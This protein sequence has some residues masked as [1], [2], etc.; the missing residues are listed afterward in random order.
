MAD[1]SIKMRELKS[2]LSRYGVDA[3]ESRGKG[4]HVLF[5]KKFAEGVFTYPVPTHN[6]DVKFVT[7]VHVERNFD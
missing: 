4:S 3:D 5:S 2:T 7:Y 1:R 6:K